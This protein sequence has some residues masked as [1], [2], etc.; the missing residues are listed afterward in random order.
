MTQAPKPPAFDPAASHQQRPRLRPVR[1]FPAQTQQGQPMLGLA[2]ARQISDRIVYCAPVVQ[3]LLPMLDGKR[4]LDDIVREVGKGLTR[5]VLEQ[6][7][8]QLDDACL[9]EGPRFEALLAKTRADFDSSVNLPP[10]ASAAFAEALVQQSV[11]QG[12]EPAP[13]S[14][15]DLASRGAAK[16]R[17]IFD[18]WMDAALKDA[19]LKAYAALPKAIVAPHLDYARGWLNYAGAWG[20]MRGVSRPD[21]VVILGTNHFGMSTGVCGCDKGYETPLGVCPADLDLIAAVRRR[22]GDANAARLF[23]NRYDHER[24]HSIELQIPWVQHVFGTDAAGN[25]PKVFAALVHDP[26]VNGGASYDG[27][28]LD[29]DPFIDALTAALAE[30]PGRTLIVSSADLSHAGPAFGDQQPLAGESPEATAFR[31]KIVQHDRD[32]L[33][34]YGSGKAEDMVASMGWQQNPTRWCSIGNMVAAM[35]LAQPSRV[36]LLN[37]AA[38]MDPQGYTFVSNASVVMT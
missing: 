36:E 34:L 37:Y 3:H 35:R 6:L 14:P 38:A 16:L 7:I 25:Y 18:Q 28:G 20:R 1:G 5:P 8:A 17:G 10:A 26:V 27:K 22:L 29:L 32:M 2:D 19:P 9:L 21:R 13:T 12:G 11:Q 31:N 15:D 4:G 30:A 33:N 24:E 23:E